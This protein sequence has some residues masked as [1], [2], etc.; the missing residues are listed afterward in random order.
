M[1][2]EII[3]EAA[4]GFMGD[5]TQSKLLI[6][7]AASSGANAVKFQLVYADELCTPDYKDYDLFKELEMTDEEWLSLH[8]YSL[9]HKIDLYTDVFGLKSLM[10]SEKIG[11]K[12]IKLHPT[13]ITNLGLLASVAKSRIPKVILGAGGANLDEIEDALKILKEKKVDLLLGFQG[14]PTKTEDNHILRLKTLGSY[15]AKKYDNYTL[16]FAD[17]AQPTDSLKYCIAI[18]A[19]GAGAKVLEKHITLGKV[20]KMEDYESALNPDEFKEFVY[21]INQCTIALGKDHKIENNFR[22][23][24]SELKYRKAIRRHVVTSKQLEKGKMITPEDVVLKRTS[25]EK[26]IHDLSLVYN[27]KLLKNLIKDEPLSNQNLV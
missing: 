12:A 18:A 15:L 2:T 22:M 6:L 23:S 20:M 1:K 4:Q 26:V 10:L 5:V 7:A 8:K 13:D 11:L 19:I 27:K 9:E 3:A 21:S 25:S 24:Q 14:Y 17:H 16:G